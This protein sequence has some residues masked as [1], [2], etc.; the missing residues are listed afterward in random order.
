[1]HNNCDRAEA[2]TLSAFGVLE[3]EEARDGDGVWRLLME[4]DIKT[5]DPI[6]GTRVGLDKPQPYD[7]CLS[8]LPFSTVLL[9]QVRQSEEKDYS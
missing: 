6:Q 3:G 9:P 1:V 2:I 4:E 5:A 8:H 7:G